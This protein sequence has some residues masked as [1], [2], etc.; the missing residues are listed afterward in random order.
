MTDEERKA[1]LKKWRRYAMLVGALLAIICKSLPHDYQAVC[2]A[3]A[4]LCTG[5]F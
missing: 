5:G 4:S 2:K 1:R 3:I